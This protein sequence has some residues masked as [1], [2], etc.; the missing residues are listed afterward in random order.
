MHFDSRKVRPALAAVL[1]VGLLVAAILPAG[2]DDPVDIPP[3]AY[4]A[5]VVPETCEANA[6]CSLSFTI[7]NVDP[8]GPPI[9]LWVLDTA[10]IEAPEGFTVGSSMSVTTSTLNGPK[11]WSGVVS[12]SL[13]TLT[14]DEADELTET[15]ALLPGE[16]VTANV[17]V[18]ASLSR[19]GPDNP[20]ATTASGTN[21][22]LPDQHT[23]FVRSGED[24]TVT[25]VNDEVTCDPGASCQTKTVSLDAV[26]GTDISKT[27]AS[28]FSD[29]GEGTAQATLQISV[30]GAFE[31][32]VKGYCKAHF[33]AKGHLVTSQVSESGK[34]RSHLVTLRLGKVIEN[35]PGAPGAASY[36]ICLVADEDFQ[37]KPGTTLTGRAVFNGEKWEGILPNC[38]AL[39]GLIT[40]C[41]RSR[42]RNSGDAI[43]KYFLN[44][45]D[46]G[47]LPGLG[48]FGI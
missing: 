10:T 1:V 22:L 35:N 6:Q 37:V 46:P 24:P 40:K 26:P 7:E 5:T 3:G 11:S 21:P 28:A 16:S 8:P 43:I 29:G 27:S 4:E 31:N 34:T 36:D 17:T 18:T 13:I 20:F 38:D 33:D 45:G 9:S 39:N 2:A 32:D 25:V 41:V 23:N 48:P 19:L 14:A 47:G 44:P 30:G 12:G 15:N 42:S